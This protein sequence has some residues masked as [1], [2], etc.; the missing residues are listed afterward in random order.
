[1]NKI[2]RA[3]MT[4]DGFAARK[5]APTDRTKGGTELS[6][7][8]WSVTRAYDEDPG[9]W[10]PIAAFKYLQ[11]ALDYIAY[12]QDRGGDVVFQTPA[13]VQEIKHTDRRVVY[14]PQ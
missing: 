10:K 9:P 3:E 11:E 12:V 13:D 6:F 14:K 4:A 2:K 8:V 7:V 5:S 1:M